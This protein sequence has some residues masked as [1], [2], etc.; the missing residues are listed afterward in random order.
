MGSKRAVQRIVSGERKYVMDSEQRQLILETA[1]AIERNIA[2]AHDCLE[3]RDGYH[4]VLF[5][6]QAMLLLHNFNVSLT[7]G[8]KLK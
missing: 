3:A 1:A 2:Y 8:A 5:V 4:A 7:K 6:E